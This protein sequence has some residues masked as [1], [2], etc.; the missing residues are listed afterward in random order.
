MILLQLQHKLEKPGL[1][2][3]WIAASLAADCFSDRN[4]G[5]DL[6]LDPA[7]TR[8]GRKEWIESLF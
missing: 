7:N 1:R 4:L 6:R 8:I 5:G 2:S 3:L